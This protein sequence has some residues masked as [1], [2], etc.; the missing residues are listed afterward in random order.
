M[1]V[2]QLTKVLYKVFSL[3]TIVRNLR[4]L[5]LQLTINSKTFNIN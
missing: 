3:L 2:L 1:L 5:V 4:K